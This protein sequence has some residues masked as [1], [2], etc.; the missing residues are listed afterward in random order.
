MITFILFYDQE[1][2]N[3]KIHLIFSR[4]QAKTNNIFTAIFYLQKHH[5]YI[6]VIFYLKKIP[7]KN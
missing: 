6:F 2:F 5:L 4:Q 7:L 3:I 1:N